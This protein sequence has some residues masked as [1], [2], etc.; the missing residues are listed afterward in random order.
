MNSKRVLLVGPRTVSVSSGTWLVPGPRV[1]WEVQAG[2]HVERMRTY[3]GR[4]NVFASAPDPARLRA[5]LGVEAHV[6]GVFNDIL[7]AEYAGDI[8]LEVCAAGLAGF[9]HVGCQHLNVAVPA[10]AAC[11]PRHQLPS[12]VDYKSPGHA[13]PTFS[14]QLGDVL[15][16]WAA[17]VGGFARLTL[18]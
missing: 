14:L 3:L 7:N 10:E 1:S 6:P 13:R 15:H 16:A 12:S 11:A 18:L 4:A 9:S 8:A 5:A 17:E 2:F